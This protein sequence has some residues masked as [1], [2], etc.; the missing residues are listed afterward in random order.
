M[1]EHTVS[2][3]V[4]RHDAGAEIQA[5]LVHALITGETLYGATVV[6]YEREAVRSEPETIAR[7]AVTDAYQARSDRGE[8]TTL[9]EFL[10]NAEMYGFSVCC[11]NDESIAPLYR[12]ASLLAHTAQATNQ[13][14][15]PHNFKFTP[16][17]ALERDSLTLLTRTRNTV[18]K[19]VLKA[20]R[21]K[22]ASV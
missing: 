19:L 22:V 21:Q 12:A 6:K 1:T 13:Y 4:L 15:T 10:K 17:S 9:L 5:K 8:L 20:K 11:N 14:L 7:S 3:V 2:T 18:D 16:G